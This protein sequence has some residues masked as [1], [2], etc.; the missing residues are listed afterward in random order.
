M[1][2]WYCLRYGGAMLFYQ[3]GFDETL[4]KHSVGLVAMGLSIKK[5]IEE[6]A[7]E[8]DLLH[9]SEAYKFQWAGD[10]RQI[11]RLELYPPHLL[12]SLYRRSVS[13][14]RTVKR[15]ARSVWPGAAIDHVASVP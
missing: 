4:A 15:V 1:A 9:G 11:G 3:S 10:S 14:K 13:L 6:G 7:A 2:S 5:A 8:Y 12:G